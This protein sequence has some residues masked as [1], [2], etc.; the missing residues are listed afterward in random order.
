M[1]DADNS[2]ADYRQAVFDP[3]WFYY[4]VCDL[5]RR[6][7]SFF[8]EAAVQRRNGAYDPQSPGSG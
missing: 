5:C 2:F 4:T 6:D 8:D 1:R 3:D 7:Q